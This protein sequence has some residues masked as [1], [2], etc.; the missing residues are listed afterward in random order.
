MHPQR[1]G[2]TL[3]MRY[4]CLPSASWLMAI[5]SLFC[6]SHLAS[7]LMRRRSLDMK[8]GAAMMAH[9]AICVTAWSR[10]SPKF[11][12]TSC[13]GKLKRCPVML[14]AQEKPG[15]HTEHL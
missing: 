14:P 6:S 3:V 2:R 1:P 8:R 15:R 12:I 5:T 4:P 7:G 13:D 11:P 10:L 9:I